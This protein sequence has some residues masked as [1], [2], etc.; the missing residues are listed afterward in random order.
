LLSLDFFEDYLLKMLVRRWSA[1]L[2]VFYVKGLVA[3][4]GTRI[5]V[6]R[7]L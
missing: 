6:E 7:E 2:R 4:L 1:T 3:K 5:G